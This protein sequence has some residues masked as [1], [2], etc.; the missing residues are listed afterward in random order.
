MFRL[1]QANA[2]WETPITSDMIEKIEMIGRVCYKTEVVITANLREWMHIMSLRFMET[3]GKVH[4]Q[5]MEVM[6]QLYKPL[7]ESELGFMFTAEALKR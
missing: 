5:M 3:T 2:V 4:P 1:L 7:S 6:K